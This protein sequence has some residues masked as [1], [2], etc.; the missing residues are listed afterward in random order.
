MTKNELNEI[1]AAD[2]RIDLADNVIGWSDT[3]DV[4]VAW[5]AEGSINNSWDRWRALLD[6]HYETIIRGDGEIGGEG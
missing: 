6:A 3:S 4:A 2:I 1:L 5:T